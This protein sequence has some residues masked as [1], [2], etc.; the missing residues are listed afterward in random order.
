VCSD[1]R[2]R[3]SGGDRRVCR[4][5]NHGSTTD[6]ASESDN[7]HAGYTDARGRRVPVRPA[8]GGTSFA[9]WGS[10]FTAACA[11]QDAAA[12]LSY[13][14]TDG[15]RILFQDLVTHHYLPSIAGAAPNTRQNTASHLGTMSGTPVRGGAYAERAVRSQLL[16]VFGAMTIGAIGPDRR[17]VTWAGRA[18]TGQDE[19]WS[20]GPTR[21]KRFPKVVVSRPVFDRLRLYIE[22]HQRGEQACRRVGSRRR[23]G[24]R[25]ARS[26][27]RV[28]RPGPR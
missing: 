19:P 18:H 9:D 17:A 16:P 23:A 12:R 6:L 7:L 28:R 25:R 11:R 8:G 21:G 26:P 27:G 13:R 10:A 3:A 20:L 4:F 24:R 22:A 5:V 15:E 14:S 1:G 2:S